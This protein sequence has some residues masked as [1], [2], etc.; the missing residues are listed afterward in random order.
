MIQQLKEIIP[1]AKVY[2]DR[3][4]FRRYSIELNVR[5]VETVWVYQNTKPSK[6]ELLDYLKRSI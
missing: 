5:G 4:A 2:L 6:L 3:K 1:A